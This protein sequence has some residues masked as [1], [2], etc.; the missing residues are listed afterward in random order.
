M[1]NRGPESRGLDRAKQAIDENPGKAAGAA[2]LGTGG[3]AASTDGGRETI[4]NAASSSESSFFESIFQ[5][6]VANPEIVGVLF[7]I[8]AVILIAMVA[9][10]PE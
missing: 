2:V 8:G 7:L 10:R 6:V 9:Q 1:S 3:A 5:A 4:S